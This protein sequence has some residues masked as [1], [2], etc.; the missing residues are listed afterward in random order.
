[1]EHFLQAEDSNNREG[2]FWEVLG[3]AGK[4]RECKMFVE[5]Y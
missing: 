2:K 1:M 4:G 5:E 3:N